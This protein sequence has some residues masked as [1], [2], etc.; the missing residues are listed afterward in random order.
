MGLRPAKH[1]NHAKKRIPYAFPR[2][3]VPSCEIINLTKPKATAPKPWFV[4]ILR[5]SNGNLYTGIATD[6]EKRLLVHN[7]GKGSAY[8]RAHRPAKLLGFIAVENRSTASILEY[9]VKALSRAGKLALI[10]KWKQQPA[11]IPPGAGC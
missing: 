7:A 6:V 4:Y 5:C 8:V 1:A 3:F 9:Q 2:V 10:K 11:S